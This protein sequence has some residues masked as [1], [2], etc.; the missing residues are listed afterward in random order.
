MMAEE[1]QRDSS[2]EGALSAIPKEAEEHLNSLQATVSGLQE[3]Q[4]A[5][6]LQLQKLYYSLHL[7]TIFVRS[8]QNKNQAFQII[9]KDSMSG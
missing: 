8:K 9:G 7:V 5:A 6:L 2:G 1:V 3:L 4:K